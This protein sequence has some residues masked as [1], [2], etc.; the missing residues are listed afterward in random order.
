[1]KTPPRSWTFGLLAALLTACSL[2]AAPDP[3]VQIQIAVNATLAALPT[4]APAP[5]NPIP[6]PPRRSC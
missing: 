5:T 2:K 1:M 6:P 4:A 3:N